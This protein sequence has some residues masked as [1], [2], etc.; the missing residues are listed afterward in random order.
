MAC[1]WS[2]CDPGPGRDGVC[3][4]AGAAGTGSAGGATEQHMQQTEAAAAAVM[5]WTACF[6]GFF[7]VPP[8]IAASR[9][10]RAIFL[11]LST[12][13]PATQRDWARVATWHGVGLF[14][15]TLAVAAAESAAALATQR[16]V[17]L[18]GHVWA[19]VGLGGGGGSIYDHIITAEPRMYV[20]D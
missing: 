7:P 15:F 12:K 3:D 4:R 11:P 20:P 1:T 14:L 13:P 8:A 18:S 9:C 19:Q 6:L 2:A 10:G 16:R 17:V 5:P